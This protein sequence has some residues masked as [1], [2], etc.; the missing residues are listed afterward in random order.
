MTAT[1]ALQKHR[2]PYGLAFATEDL[3]EIGRWAQARQ[4]VMLIV[5]DHVVNEFEFEE[6]IVLSTAR[7]RERRVMLW[8]SFGTIYAQPVFAKPRG[9]ATVPQA[10]NWLS[11]GPSAGT[12]T[13][14][15][16]L[17]N[18]WRALAPADRWEPV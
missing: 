3:E 7:H 4:L 9:F 13:F 2:R 11:P 15:G 6:M 14:A 18:V 12:T 5:L 1:P 10:L 16:R 8:R 17:R